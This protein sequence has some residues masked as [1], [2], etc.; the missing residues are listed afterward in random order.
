MN[1]PSDYDDFAE[2]YAAGIDD[3]AWNALYERP[4]TLALLPSVQ[5]KDI[6]DA[7]C[8]NGWY[9]E[10]LV[11]NGGRVVGVD[12]SARMVELA[13]KRLGS[14][15]RLV[16]ADVSDLRGVLADASVDIVLS[17]L[18]L[19]YVPDLRRTFLEW[20]RILRPGGTMVFSTHHPVRETSVAEHGYLHAEIVEEPWRWLGMKMRYYHRPLRDLTEPMAEA[21]FVIERIC[22]PTPS[23]ALRAR[24][25]KG[26]DRLCRVPAFIFMRARKDRS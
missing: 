16:Q 5:G 13:T 4:S 7:G 14:K 24:D 9:A 6:L 1:A 25:P 3:R 23:A 17:S 19:H 22:E 2:R 26:Y 20:A 12:R 11:L 8:G 21:G 18:V 10:W 15:A